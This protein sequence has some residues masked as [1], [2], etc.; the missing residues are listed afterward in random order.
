MSAQPATAD[1]QGG[2]SH[3]QAAQRYTA[4]VLAGTI[5]AC[6]WTQLAAQR[7]RDD[8]ARSARVN[9]VQACAL[10][11]PDDA[12]AQAEFAQAVADWPW[13]FDAARAARPCEFIELLPHIKGKWARLKE[14]IV[15]E[16]WQSFIVTT[17][18][19]WVHRDT[20]LRR[21][22]DVY[23]E[24][25]RKN[26]KST[27]SSGIALYM[28]TA[29]G[30]QGAEIYS[31]AT[32]SE[33]ARIVF[34]VARQMALKLPEMRQHLG[35]AILT[36]S[37]TVA[38]AASSFRPLAA[39]SST[40]DGLNIHLAVVDELHAHKTRGLYDVLDT[41]RGAHPERVP[42]WFARTGARF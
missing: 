37:L 24:V 15:L 25:P 21:F 29:D 1:L 23:L 6:K 11:A 9:A 8:L 35:L 40:Q 39:E 4:G 42:R 31:A 17:I 20:G 18:F 27:L 38:H 36:H 7:Q 19:G 13:V 41:A 28:L 26:A 14:T 5:P 33:Q 10:A 2:A 30:E 12:A 22:R 16:P 32:T 34:D 3:V